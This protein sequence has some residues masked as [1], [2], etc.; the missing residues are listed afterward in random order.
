MMR[1]A[2]I[3]C[4]TSEWQQDGRLLG[5]VELPL[6]DD[7]E[8]V[9]QG[10]VERLRELRLARIYH[11]PDE[12]A[13]A[14]ACRLGEE[15]HVPTKAA[16]EL[17]EV[18]LGLWTGL[19][20]DQLRERFASAYRQLEE[21]PLTVE[22]PGGEAFAAA[23]DRLR[24]WLRARL[25]RRAAAAAGAVVRPIAFSMLRGLLADGDASA[26]WEHLADQPNLLVAEAAPR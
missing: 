24:A 2:L 17:E 4:A 19:T 12:L 5:R 18:D 6:A 14:M 1:L 23:A 16:P 7:A 20:Q 25:R 21:S 26:F 10:W 8:L 15:L 22:P 13:V 11:A 3:P 9:P